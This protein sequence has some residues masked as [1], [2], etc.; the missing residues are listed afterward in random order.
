MDRV[1]RLQAFIK[2]STIRKRVFDLVLSANEFVS[3]IEISRRSKLPVSLVTRALGQLEKEGD[4]A[5]DK[6][7]GWWI[8]Y[9]PDGS[10]AP[11]PGIANG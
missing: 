8:I 3:P 10:I 4:Y 7:T 6:E 2:S 11:V 1:R 9:R 5:D